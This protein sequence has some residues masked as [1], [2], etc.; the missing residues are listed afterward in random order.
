[1]DRFSNSP[2]PVA[3]PSRSRT[4]FRTP[5]IQL[6]YHQRPPNSSSSSYSAYSYGYGSAPSYSRSSTPVLYP[7]GAR[8][9]SASIV[10]ATA[11]Q[12]ED[13]EIR[14]K[15][16]ESVTRLR[17]AWDL[18]NEKY[19]SVALEDDDE[20]DLRTGEIVRDR[21]KLRDFVRRE[22]GEVSDTDEGDDVASSVIGGQDTADIDS[23]EDELGGWENKSGLDPQEFEHPLVQEDFKPW[24]TA[25]D[26]EDLKEFYKLEAE[27][28]RAAGALSRNDGGSES[29]RSRSSSTTT[30]KMDGDGRS[31]PRWRGTEIL[32]ARLEDLFLSDGDGE[33][34]TSSEDELDLTRDDMDDEATRKTPAPPSMK[35]S[36]TIDFEYDGPPRRSILEVVIPTRSRRLVEGSSTASPSPARSLSRSQSPAHSAALSPVILRDLTYNNLMRPASSPTL[37]DL[38]NSP[39]PVASSSKIPVSAVGS[40]PT[41][42]SARSPSPNEDECAKLRSPLATTTA[43]PTPPRTFNESGS[44]AFLF[45]DGASLKGKERMP[46]ER[47]IELAAAR[48]HSTSARQ[49]IGSP[50]YC[51]NVWRTRSGSLHA[52]RSCSAAGGERAVMASLCKGRRGPCPF[53]E[54]E[55]E[56]ADSSMSFDIHHSDSGGDY[57]PTAEPRS[58]SWTSAQPRARIRTCRLCREAGG[59][60]AK[61]ATTC[62]GRATF[63][64][65]K[66]AKAGNVDD[67]S[68]DETS[69]VRLQSTTRAPSV[70]VRSAQ[71]STAD[72]D[73]DDTPLKRSIVQKSRK[74]KHVIKSESEDDMF[75]PSTIKH[76]SRSSESLVPRSLSKASPSSR[77]HDLDPEIYAD[78]LSFGPNGRPRRCPHCRA[79][80]G[81]RGSRAWWCKG[82]TWSKQCTFLNTDVNSHEEVQPSGKLQRAVGL[83]GPLDDDVPDCVEQEA[84]GDTRDE[85]H[86]T[87]KTKPRRKW[88][89]RTAPP[90]SRAAEPSSAIS[91][92]VKLPKPVTPSYMLTPP[93]TSSVEPSS[94]ERE[95]IPFTTARPP[96]KVRSSSTVSSSM[97]PSSPPVSFSTLASSSENHVRPLPTP[98]PSVSVDFPHHRRTSSPAQPIPTTIT[99][100]RRGMTVA[101]H[102]TPPSSTDDNR[103]SSVASDHVPMTLPRK[104][105]LRRPSDS[106]AP[107]STGS[108]KRARFSLQPRSSPREPSS[109]PFDDYKNAE[110]DQHKGDDGDSEDELSLRL[111]E[112]AESSPF[113]SSSPLNYPRYVA[114]SSPLRNE[115]SVRAADV[116]FKLGPEHTG[117]IS[118]DMLKALAPALPAFRPTLGSSVHTSAPTSST[119]FA[120]STPPVSCD[121]EFCENSSARAAS[122]GASSNDI[123]PSSTPQDSRQ[124]LMLPPPVPVKRPATPSTVTLPGTAAE[125]KASQES[126][127][128]TNNAM[129]PARSRSAS[130]S[131]SISTSF[132]PEGVKT[133]QS[134]AVDGQS[135][136]YPATARRY[137]TPSREMGTGPGAACIRGASSTPSRKTKIKLKAEIKSLEQI[138][139]ELA[140]IAQQATDEDGLEWGL[141]EDCEDEDGGRM[142]REGSVIRHL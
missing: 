123:G 41:P 119:G 6:D 4:P 33:R 1:M 19:G 120:L 97:P 69:T 127:Q 43:S 85:I 108:V 98:S 73:S 59:E 125:S 76:R 107:S 10:N 81:L 26:L 130:T 37:A 70:P 22:F 13:A 24:D 38:F 31:M 84:D 11:G 129:H 48:T 86:A 142:W 17:T 57:S 83:G 118:T 102:P 55:V 140:M 124:G 89:S 44:P 12:K 21:G 20:I 122:A 40:S 138:E 49:Q 99:L 115:W 106:S 132:K 79:A 133:P 82:R 29:P 87:S 77:P 71:A 117:R 15:R 32:P 104:S 27:R 36:F 128:Y 75:T 18:I 53:Q 52:C 121:A 56:K 65:C 34:E 109:D 78:G 136:I 23:D 47:P 114:S 67:A 93:P 58:R 135:R 8:F 60:R 66:Y 54:S 103:G 35:D 74:G 105:A 3:G 95:D 112:T 9:R 28:A 139:K 96:H 134:S 61:N 94:P 131:T 116:G 51:K 100:P 16:V 2:A 68:D 113:P 91:V 64:N 101:G 46:D 14:R 50:F 39:P 5:L 126:I 62:N 137:I 45:T 90:P 63:R 25:E 80:Q 141:D 111:G 88:H 7:N 72:V 30:D 110:P 42:T 92:L